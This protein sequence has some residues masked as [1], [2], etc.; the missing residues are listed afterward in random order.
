M[1]VLFV[2]VFREGLFVVEERND[3]RTRGARVSQ[4]CA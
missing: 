3:L 2:L 1:F 4:I